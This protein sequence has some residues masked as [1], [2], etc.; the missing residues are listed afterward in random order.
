MRRF[1]RVSASQNVRERELSGNTVRR[2]DAETDTAQQVPDAWPA[3]D[4]RYVDWLCF[5]ELG[6]RSMF[7]M[8]AT[9]IVVLGCRG[10]GRRH[11]VR[12]ARLGLPH[13]PVFVPDADN[14]PV[15][16]YRAVVL[17]RLR[18]VGIESPR[19]SALAGIVAQSCKPDQLFLHGGDF[20]VRDRSSGRD[21]GYAFELPFCRRCSA[22]CS[23]RYFW[24]SW[25]RSGGA[26][27][28]RWHSA[29]RTH[30]LH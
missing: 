4:R 17:A 30:R 8:L 23:F 22:T 7:T 14:V 1:S 26:L 18:L 6:Y 15:A 21:L 3:F 2:K 10:G 13:C 12:R 16:R 24:H 11:R 28:L 19:R 5:G 29:I 25:R 20:G 27:Y 9:R